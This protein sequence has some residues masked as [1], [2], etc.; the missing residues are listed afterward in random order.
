MIRFVFP[1]SPRQLF[2]CL[3]KAALDK[4]KACQAAE[5]CLEA[6]QARS[7]IPAQTAKYNPVEITLWSSPEGICSPHT[8]KKDS[9]GIIHGIKVEAARKARSSL[10]RLQHL[11]RAGLKPI[12]T[13]RT[14]GVE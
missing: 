9:D 5:R 2:V 14:Y 10:E 8:P 4:H 11:R 3:I 13:G 12:T 1:C 6:P 7:S